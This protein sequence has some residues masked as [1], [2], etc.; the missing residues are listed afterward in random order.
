MHYYQSTMNYLPPPIDLYWWNF[1]HIVIIHVHRKIEKIESHG[2]SVSLKPPI[3]LDQK[4]AD[5]Y[6]SCQQIT[7]GVVI[8][9]SS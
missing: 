8:T 5:W 1:E 9:G 3:L 6:F 4:A 2:A 7:C